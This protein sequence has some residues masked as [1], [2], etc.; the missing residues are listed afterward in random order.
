MVT[1][2][3]GWSREMASFL[4][5]IPFRVGGILL[6]IWALSQ[7]VHVEEIF[8]YGTGNIEE[9]NQLLSVLPHVF[10]HGSIKVAHAQDKAVVKKNENPSLVIPHW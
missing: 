10:P 1:L 6:Y 2:K 4:C 7:M 8:Q 9:E 5:K 3:V